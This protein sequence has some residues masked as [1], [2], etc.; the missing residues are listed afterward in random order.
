MPPGA[1]VTAL[2]VC[3]KGDLMALRVVVCFTGGV[4]SQV[5]R[6]LH[7]DPGFELVGVLVYHEDKDGRDAGEVVGI[8]NIGVDHD[9]RRG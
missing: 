9:P 3:G 1:L 4:G 8:G 6:L 2:P 7:D 5:V